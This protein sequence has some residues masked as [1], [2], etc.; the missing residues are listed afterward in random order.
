SHVVLIAGVA[1]VALPV[2]IAL[3]ASTQGS[4][5]FLSGVLPMLPGGNAWQNYSTMLGTGL[6]RS[7]APPLGPMLLNSLVMA[8]AISIGKIAISIVSAYAIVYFRFPGR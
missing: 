2:Y 1:I 6:T 5:D 7:G 3:I 4:N 8:L